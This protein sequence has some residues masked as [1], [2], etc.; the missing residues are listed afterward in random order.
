MTQSQYP[1][2]RLN[3]NA[4]VAEALP[5]LLGYQ[6]VERLAVIT[7]RDRELGLTISQE[8]D[9]ETSVAVT[10]A[11]TLG[12][13]R[14]VVREEGVTGAL[15]VAVSDR[16][17]LQLGTSMQIALTRAGIQVVNFLVVAGDQVASLMDD[18]P[19]QPLTMTTLSADLLEHT[20][21]P[22]PTRDQLLDPVKA[23]RLTTD[24]HV[25]LMA[26]VMAMVP[27]VAGGDLEE[28]SAEVMAWLVSEQPPTLVE[29]GTM[30][31][32][33]RDLVIRDRALNLLVKDRETRDR[34]ASRCAWLAQIVPGQLRNAPLT[35]WAVAKWL[36]GDG[37][38]FHEASAAVLAVEPNYTLMKLMRQGYDWGMGPQQVRSLIESIADEVQKPQG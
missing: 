32:A 20:A 13:M 37:A 1:T 34:V 16:Q 21:L 35:V 28:L 29:A 2:V 24:Q 11:K 4:S 30:V 26:S 22:A 7:L 3:D 10:E 33:F 9:D 12:M 18:K 31:S 27:R 17:R 15:L 25:E 8:L 19:A 6:P 38:S 5:F 36:S 23:V 14:A